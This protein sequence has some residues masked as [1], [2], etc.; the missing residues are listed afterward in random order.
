MKQFQIELDEMVCIWL[1]HIAKVTGQSVE[2]AISNGI[3]QQIASLEESAV[4]AFTYR[5]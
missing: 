2:E 5:K 1:K 3:F 4:K